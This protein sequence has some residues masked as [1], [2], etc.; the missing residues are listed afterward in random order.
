MGKELCSGPPLTRHPRRPGP[1]SHSG[2]LCPVGNRQGQATAG[3]PPDL[4]PRP[5]AHSTPSALLPPRA[6][7]SLGDAGTP[8]IPMGCVPWEIAV[9]APRQPRAQGVSLGAGGRQVAPPGALRTGVGSGLCP[10]GNYAGPPP[11][12]VPERRCASPYNGPG[13]RATPTSRTWGP[14]LSNGRSQPRPS[15]SGRTEG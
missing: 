7:P 13:R 10:S 11:G 12:Q 1:S 5:A 6:E 8:L 4:S 3:P 15:T 2:Q 14:G 9:R